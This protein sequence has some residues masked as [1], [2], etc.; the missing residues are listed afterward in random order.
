MYIFFIFYVYFTCK[1]IKGVYKIMEIKEKFS[2]LPIKVFSFDFSVFYVKNDSSFW[3]EIIATKDDQEYYVCKLDYAKTSQGI[4]TFLLKVLTTRLQEKYKNFNF[5]V[6]KS[7]IK[8]ND[9]I[10]HLKKENPNLN[11]I[12]Y[13]DLE[14]ELKEYIL[15]L[16]QSQPQENITLYD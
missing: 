5:K 15:T 14:Q 16:Q 8:V 6:L 3:Y 10:F 7:G 9:K 4:K 11:N 1:Q 13:Y 2:N 12:E